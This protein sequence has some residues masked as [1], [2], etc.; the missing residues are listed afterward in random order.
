MARRVLY[1]QG[2]DNK[3]SH[4]LEGACIRGVLR[5]L[6]NKPPPPSGPCLLLIKGACFRKDMV[7][8]Y[9]DLNNEFGMLQH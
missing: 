7:C 9:D 2:R 8:S 1:R 3:Q 6:E 5:I 4:L